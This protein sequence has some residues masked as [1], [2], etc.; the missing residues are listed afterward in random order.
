RMVVTRPNFTILDEATSALDLKNEEKL[1]EQLQETKTTFISVGHRESL[2]NYH[3]W[4]LELTENSR[5]RIVSVSDYRQQKAIAIPT[6]E[7]SPS[8]IDN[9]PP[10]LPENISEITIE[11]VP[12]NSPPIPSE[13][14]SEI[15]AEIGSIIGLS[16]K[17]IQQLTNY[18]I[19]SIRSMASQGKTVTTEDGGTYY[20]NKDPKV[21]KWVPI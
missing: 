8:S 7:S 17:E 18:Q 20:Y 4:V 1:Y 21:L 14:I 5:W 3:K 10:I 13:N 6:P 19:S 12:D 11:I 2:F 16:H 15:S 9:S